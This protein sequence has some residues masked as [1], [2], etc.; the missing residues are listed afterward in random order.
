M[1]VPVSTK[2]LETTYLGGAAHMLTDTG[3]HVVV[4]NPHQTDGVGDIVGQTTG[5]DT[6]RQFVTS[7]ELISHWQVVAN[8][9]I[10]PRFNLLL[11]LTARLVIEMKTHLTLL[12]LDMSIERALTPEKPDH[13]L[14]QKMFRRM[15]RRK[16]FLIVV[17]QDIVFHKPML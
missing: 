14:V 2:H 3:A 10:H 5:I 15:G 4:A 8:Q 7:H 12:P 9:F 13:R 17:V 6:F 16:L 11:L 1:F